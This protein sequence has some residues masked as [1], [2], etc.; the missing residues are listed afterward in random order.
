MHDIPTGQKVPDSLTAV[1]DRLNVKERGLRPY[2]VNPRK[3]AG[4]LHLGSGIVDPKRRF[5]PLQRF[6]EVGT[7]AASRLTGMLKAWF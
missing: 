7:G 1:I 6:R 5:W 3:R 4:L 2:M